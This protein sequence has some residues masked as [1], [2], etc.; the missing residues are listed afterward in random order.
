MNRLDIDKQS[1]S[2][3]PVT[4]AKKTWI[5]PEIRDQSIESHTE[6]KETSNP[7]EASASTGS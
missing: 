6:G 7:T 1:S 5:N 3:L 2:K 4:T